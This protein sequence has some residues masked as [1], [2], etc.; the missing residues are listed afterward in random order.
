MSAPKLPAYL[1]RAC[2]LLSAGTMRPPENRIARPNGAPSPA[3]ASQGTVVNCMGPMCMW[4]IGA[5]DE[6]G[7]IVDGACATAAQF[8]GLQ[9]LVIALSTPSAPVT[10]TGQPAGE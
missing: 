7:N 5:A 8:Q 9:Q 1:T 3:N 6:K 2:P 10:E 4:F